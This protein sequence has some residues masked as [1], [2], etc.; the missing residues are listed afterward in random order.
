MQEN[1]NK[2]RQRN[3][4]RENPRDI[5]PSSR[6]LEKFEDAV[7]HSVEKLIEMAK[8]EQDYRHKWQTNYSSSYNLSYRIGQISGL[9][10]NVILLF[11]V[12]NLISSGEKELGI[13][14]FTINAALMAFAV[15]ITIVER[16]VFA[17]RPSNRQRF[18]DK[19]NQKVNS[20]NKNR[21]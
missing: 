19:K 4:K 12:Y 2:N 17:K 15:I 16:R 20:E 5:L 11:V 10:Y 21:S 9:I 1:R 3:N 7:P 6:I 13:K 18:K 8:K 14:I